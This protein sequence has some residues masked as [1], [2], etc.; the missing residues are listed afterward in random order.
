MSTGGIPAIPSADQ[1]S[2]IPLPFAPQWRF[3]RINT[4]L[5]LPKFPI[6]LRTLRLSI[7]NVG[8]L[9]GSAVQVQILGKNGPCIDHHSIICMAN[10]YLTACANRCMRERERIVTH[11]M[12]QMTRHNLISSAAPDRNGTHG[13][14]RWS[15]LLLAEQ[16][17]CHQR[18]SHQY[19]IKT[20][21]CWKSIRMFSA[22]SW[23]VAARRTCGRKSC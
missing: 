20:S 22:S 16:G 17:G 4:F 1:V 15:S 2:E 14:H 23:A 6:S 9:G 8:T 21:L 7:A 5:G 11:P 13:L 3:H 12:R 19:G 18:Q 10:L